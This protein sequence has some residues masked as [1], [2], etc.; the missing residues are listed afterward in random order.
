L[1][2]RTPTN[3]PGTCGH[4]SEGKRGQVVRNA[5]IIANDVVHYS[6][7][8]DLRS[9][10]TRRDVKDAY[11]LTELSNNAQALQAVHA[12]YIYCNANLFKFKQ[13]KANLLHVAL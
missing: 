6:G 9:C 1:G 3:C 13:A 5:A 10:S 8:K 2:G 11:I 7:C 12:Y 4:V